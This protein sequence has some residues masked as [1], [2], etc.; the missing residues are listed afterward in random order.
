MRRAV[1]IVGLDTELELEKVTMIRTPKQMIV[2]EQMP[3]GGWRLTYSD[4][5]IPDI[6]KVEALRFIRGD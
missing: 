6:T 3:S 5:V 2:L 1:E 4:G